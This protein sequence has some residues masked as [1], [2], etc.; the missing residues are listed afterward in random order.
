LSDIDYYKYCT[1]VWIRSL[2]VTEVSLFMSKNIQI[3]EASGDFSV[4]AELLVAK[5]QGYRNI[6]VH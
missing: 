6:H 3:N 5:A 1:V 4:P 2:G